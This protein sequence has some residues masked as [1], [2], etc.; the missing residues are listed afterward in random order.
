MPVKNTFIQFDE[1][2][3]GSRRESLGAPEAPLLDKAEFNF[4]QEEP[5]IFGLKS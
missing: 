1:R 2:I 3:D 5:G 4:D